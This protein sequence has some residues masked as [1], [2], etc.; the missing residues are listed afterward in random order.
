[1]KRESEA[2]ELAAAKVVER[3]MAAARNHARS[4]RAKAAEA[5]PFVQQDA[6]IHAG[7]A[8]ELVAKALLAQLD[9]R[10][11]S[12]GP[13]AHHALLD[14]LATLASRSGVTPAPK[15]GSK[16]LMAWDAVHLACR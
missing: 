5:D 7:T 14:V 6:A 16:T 15:A 8:V 10:L 9:F 2:P 13:N 3:L 12:D 11:L 4:A 1:M